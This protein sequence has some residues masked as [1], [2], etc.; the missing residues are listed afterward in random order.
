MA[1]SLFKHYERERER[2]QYIP[3]LDREEKYESQVNQYPG[4]N[5]NCSSPPSSPIK[6]MSGCYVTNIF[7]TRTSDRLEVS[8]HSSHCPRCDRYAMYG[9]AYLRQD[10][11]AK[12]Q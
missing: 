6:Y 1:K 12:T 11:K 3:L 2:I 7:I 10:P 8:P 9:L 5:Q 4:N